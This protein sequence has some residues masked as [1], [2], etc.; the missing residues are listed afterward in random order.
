MSIPLEVTKR[1]EGQR[2]RSWW[3]PAT[4]TNRLLKPIGIQIATNLL[5]GPAN[6]EH[7]KLIGVKTMPLGTNYS[8]YCLECCQFSRICI[9]S[10]G[11][12]CL[13]CCRTNKF[14]QRF[15]K[16]IITLGGLHKT[17]YATFYRP[18]TDQCRNGSSSMLIPYRE[19]PRSTRI[20]VAYSWPAFSAT[21]RTNHDPISFD[22]QAQV[23]QGHTSYINREN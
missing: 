6:R 7:R 3:Q 10:Y 16:D 12:D 13:I 22:Q 17:S 19:Q 4:Q 20:V 18:C 23:F 2:V 15:T 21:K 11:E 5:S 1:Y 8:F 14:I 9:T